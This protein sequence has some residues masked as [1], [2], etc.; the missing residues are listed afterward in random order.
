MGAKYIL[1]VSDNCPK[2]RLF[3]F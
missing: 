3:V 2:V 1:K